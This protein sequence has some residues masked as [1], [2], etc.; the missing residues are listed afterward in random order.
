MKWDMVCNIWSPPAANM[1]DNITLFYFMLNVVKE[2]SYSHRCGPIKLL[3][4]TVF[5]IQKPHD[6]FQG[7]FFWV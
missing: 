7:A 5:E 4:E 1:L 3:E 6:I 2:T